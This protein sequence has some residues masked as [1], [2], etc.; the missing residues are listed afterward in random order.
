MNI[1][2]PLSDGRPPRWRWWSR[3]RWLP[4]RPARLARARG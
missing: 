1:G 2:F 4:C 3:H